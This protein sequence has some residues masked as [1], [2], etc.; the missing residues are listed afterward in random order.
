VPKAGVEAK[1]GTTHEAQPVKPDDQPTGGFPEQLDP[2]IK[3]N[4]GLPAP[5]PA[6]TAAPVAATRPA[7]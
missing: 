6:T 3:Q 1:E 2:A 4:P 5:T 7:P